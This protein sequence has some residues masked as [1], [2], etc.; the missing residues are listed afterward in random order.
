MTALISWMFHGIKYYYKQIK[1][2]IKCF[3]LMTKQTKKMQ[4]LINCN[5]KEE[6][7]IVIGPIMFYSLHNMYV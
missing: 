5:G 1:C 4:W 6:Y 7:S 2:M 3:Y